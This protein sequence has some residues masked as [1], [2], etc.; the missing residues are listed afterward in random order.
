MKAS[1]RTVALSGLAALAVAMGIGRFAFTPILPM[2]QDDAGVTLRQGGWLASANYVGYLLGALAATRPWLPRVT[3]IRG[4]LALI[5]LAT[6]AMAFERNLAAWMLLRALPGFASAWVLVQVSA[7]TLERLGQEGR[8]ALGGVVYAGVGAGI[9]FTGAACLALSSVHAG[10]AIAWLVLG[11]SAAVACAWVWPLV[12]EAQSVQPARQPRPAA[13][14]TAQFW[15][16]VLCYGA[17]GFGYI[18]PATYLPVMAKQVIAD[19]A[20]FGWAWPVFGAAALVSTLAGARLSAALG[21]RR[22]WVLAN[23]VMALGAVLPAVLDGLGG[24]VAGA[25][26]VGGTFMVLTMVGMQEARRVGGE[27]APA[28]MAAMT[29]AFAIGQI[30]GPVLVSGLARQPAGMSLAL[31]V[32][33]ACLVAAAY[34]VHAMEEI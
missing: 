29:S 25:L 32:A 2:M 15:P 3:A 22:L 19:P 24:I 5:A 16:L 12:G 13:A 11:V 21:A 9:V 23:L 14:R 7:W 17:F 34:T 27:G 20:V 1:A 18:I 26:A 31:A 10:S 30:A 8:P 28:L 4:G 33:A 6:M